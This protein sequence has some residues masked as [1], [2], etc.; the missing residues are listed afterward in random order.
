MLSPLRG[1][2]H[3]NGNPYSKQ[4]L[5]GVGTQSGSYKAR[6][7]CEWRQRAGTPHAVK[8]EKDRSILRLFHQT[9]SNENCFEFIWF[10]LYTIKTVALKVS[11]FAF[12]PP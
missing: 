2:R 3:I 12:I 7:A 8:F 10:V 1:E 6:L 5:G 4:V 11:M 9:H